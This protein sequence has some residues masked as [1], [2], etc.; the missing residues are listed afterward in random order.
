MKSSIAPVKI[1]IIGGTGLYNLTI[2]KQITEKQVETPFGKVFVFYFA[3][4][5]LCYS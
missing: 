4:A 1:G 3:Y 5:S 2:L